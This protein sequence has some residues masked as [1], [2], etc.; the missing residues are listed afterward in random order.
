MAGGKRALTS[1]FGAVPTYSIIYGAF[2]TLPIFLVWI[3]LSWVIVLLGAVI[4]AYAPLVG[5]QMTRWPDAPGSEFH[6]ALVVLAHLAQARQG[7]GAAARSTR[8]PRR[9]ASIRCRST[10]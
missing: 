3:Y 8:S 4:A 9:S 2:A 7:D 6:L 10:R 5:K 1:Y